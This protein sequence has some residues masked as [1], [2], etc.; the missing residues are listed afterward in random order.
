MTVISSRKKCFSKFPQ[1]KKVK[2]V[3]LSLHFQLLPLKL[4]TQQQN[5]TKKLRWAR[6]QKKSL[7]KWKNCMEKEIFFKDTLRF[8]SYFLNGLL[9]TFQC[10]V[11]LTF[12]LWSYRSLTLL[13]LTIYIPN[14]IEK[15]QSKRTSRN[16][17]IEN[18]SFLNGKVVSR[19]KS[20][21]HCVKMF[22]H[23]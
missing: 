13:L 17:Q 4:S 2:C 15:F 16:N 11:F 20:V 18:W 12:G 3:I 9:D 6:P 21:S 7:K 8:S 5:P 22:F 19:V 1:Q 10:K 14:K 23:A